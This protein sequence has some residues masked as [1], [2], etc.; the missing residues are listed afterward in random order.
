MILPPMVCLFWQVLPIPATA[1]GV[2]LQ[3]A[4]QQ[5]AVAKVALPWI[6]MWAPPVSSCVLEQ[7][8]S[9]VCAVVWG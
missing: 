8:F 3:A 2:E 4:Q 9:R 6:Q 5:C 7:M 1:G